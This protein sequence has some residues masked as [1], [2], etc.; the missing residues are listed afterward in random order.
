MSLTDMFMKKLT[1][2]L[3]TAAGALVLAALPAVAQSPTSDQILGIGE[4][5]NSNPIATEANELTN[6]NSFLYYDPNFTLVDANKF[7]QATEIFSG[8][9]VSDIFGVAN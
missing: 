5:I 8:G 4:T 9:T 7:G 3:I 6:G 2:T 1:F